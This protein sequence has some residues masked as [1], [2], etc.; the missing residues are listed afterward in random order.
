MRQ[1]QNVKRAANPLTVPPLVLL[2]LTPAQTRAK[3]SNVWN[4]LAA[5]AGDDAPRPFRSAERKMLGWLLSVKLSVNPFRKFTK[6]VA[7]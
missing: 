3:G 2:G 7:S 6:V 5:R 4:P 1:T